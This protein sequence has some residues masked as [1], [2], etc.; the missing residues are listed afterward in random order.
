MSDLCCSTTLRH[1]T[2]GSLMNSIIENHCVVY[3]DE[4]QR[5]LLAVE[6][7]LKEGENVGYVHVWNYYS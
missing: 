7:T 6:A 2:C 1:V 3:I 5:H 4:K